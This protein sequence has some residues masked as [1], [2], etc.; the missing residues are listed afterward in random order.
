MLS[1]PKYFPFHAHSAEVPWLLSLSR[2]QANFFG[3]YDRPLGTSQLESGAVMTKQTRKRMFSGDEQHEV[4]RRLDASQ[5]TESRYGWLP[6][7]LP[8]CR[9]NIDNRR[10]RNRMSQRASRE[11]Q[12]LYIKELENKLDRYCTSDTGRTAALEKENEDL[13]AQL[14][15]IHKKLCSVQATLENISNSAA[16]V[17]G[18]KVGSFI[19]N[20][21]FRY[22]NNLG[23]S[24]RTQQVQR[25]TKFPQLCHLRILHLRPRGMCVLPSPLKTQPFRA[26]ITAN[27]WPGTK[28]GFPYLKGIIG[29]ATM[30]CSIIRAAKGSVSTI[31]RTRA[32]YHPIY[33]STSTVSNAHLS[34]AM[35]RSRNLPREAL[36]LITS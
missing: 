1:F 33:M 35:S 9:L 8:C 29:P 20:V 28:S 2:S 27:Y 36:C 21:E 31:K 17:L 34:T 11:R 16:M 14:R 22:R 15:E 4:P 26:Q 23:C 6:I 10:A 32:A 12:T 3:R 30:A 24:Q 7:H 18:H 19:V 25:R 5:K 13:R